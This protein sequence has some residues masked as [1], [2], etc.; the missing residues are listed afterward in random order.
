MKL[1]FKAWEYTQDDKFLEAR[2][3]FEGD[4]NSGWNIQRNEMDYLQLGKGYNL[5]KSK[6]CGICS[7]DIA[8]RFLPFPLPQ[9]TGHEIVAESMD[10]KTQY[11]VEINDTDQ[12]RGTVEDIFCSS[13]IPTHSP[14]RLVL[15]IDRL[16]GGFG[17]YFLAPIHA[18]IPFQSKD[19]DPKVAVLIEPFAACL[20][21]VT[22]SPPRN[23]DRVAVLGPRRLGNLLIAAL[24]CYR[25]IYKID[26]EIV[27]IAR[28]D[29]LLQIS[30]KLGADTLLRSDSL[31]LE[32]Q[33][34]IVYDTTSTESGFLLA[35]ELA[36]R[37]LHLKTTNGKEMSGM[38]KLTEL[39]VDELTILPMNEKNLE[40]HWNDAHYKNEK[41][42]IS[43]KLNYILKDN[44]HFF[45]TSISEAEQVL[46]SDEFA[47]RLPRFDLAIVQ[48]LEE[49][50]ACIRP[51]SENE[52]SLVRP[53][54]AIILQ[55]PN[56]ENPIEKFLNQGGEIHSSRCGDF[57]LALDLLSKNPN[58]AKSLIENLITHTFKVKD[59]NEAFTIAKSPDAVKVIIE[60]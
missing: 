1:N 44:A 18:A 10:G 22:S 59:M 41:I 39:V 52:N 27:S 37:E 46:Q 36:K 42:Y 35:L 51:N 54:G 17:P 21:A 47:N 55:N 53:R 15:G 38:K 3:S 57:H 9:I 7:T 5:F 50:D 20:Q 23:G 4:S 40:F 58:V 8:R 6:F 13:G 11:V 30:K 2:Y 45:Q 14:T 29:E 43:P 28:H 25:N 33:F 60:H 16:P 34:D 31:K 19:L 32:R 56:S 26:F 24:S 48:S 49:I 12:A